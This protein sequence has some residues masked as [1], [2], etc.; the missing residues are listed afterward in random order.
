MKAKI[1]VMH[2]EFVATMERDGDWIA[3]KLTHDVR[4]YDG[5]VTKAAAERAL[6]ERHDGSENMF[7]N[8]L[9]FKAITETVNI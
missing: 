2:I 4:G 5:K 9:S 1:K 8:L 7:Y 3:M 6:A